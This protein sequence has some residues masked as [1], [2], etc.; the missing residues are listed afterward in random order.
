MIRALG[1]VFIFLLIIVG[2][3]LGVGRA[4]TQMTGGEKKGGAIVG[5][6]PEAGESI[7]W[8]KGRCWT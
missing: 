5:I 8:G 1:K 4:V 3:F 7:F 6:N 2:L